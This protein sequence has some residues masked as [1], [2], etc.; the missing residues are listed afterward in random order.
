MHPEVQGAAGCVFV[1]PV[2]STSAP[3]GC[4]SVGV[5]A[6]KGR[7][8]VE[9]GALRRDVARG[10]GAVASRGS[11]A[12]AGGPGGG[13]TGAGGRTG[14]SG[15]A[16]GTVTGAVVVMGGAE[17]TGAGIVGVETLGAGEGPE[18]LREVRTN[19]V[20]APPARAR[21]PTATSGLAQRR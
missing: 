20:I 18:P 4:P 2:R 12:S 17:T 14:G 10:A 3:C 6:G 7:A 15:A 16:E 8:V 21:H 13:A 9:E 1:A 11:A 5:P 19:A